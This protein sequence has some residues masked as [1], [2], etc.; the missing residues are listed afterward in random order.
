[1]SDLRQAVTDY[2]A[3][4]RALGSKL[5]CRHQ[6]LEDF[7]AFL[8]AAGASTITTE[9]ALAWATRPGDDAHPTYLSNRLCAV[10]GFARHLQPS[11]R[12]PRCRRL[13]C[14]LAEMPAVPYLYSD[15]DIAALMG[16]ARSLTPALRTAT[17][18]T[19]IGALSVTGMRV[20]EGLRLNRDDVDFDEGC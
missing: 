2:I 11:T 14:S 18:E 5:E 7:V 17:Y 3:V 10:R 20:G 13:S 19:L 12:P 1:V 16:A 8:E 9:L 6:L 15:A 4:R